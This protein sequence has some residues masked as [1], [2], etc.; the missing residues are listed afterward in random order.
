MIYPGLV[1]VTFRDHAPQDVLRFAREAG[2]QS[3]EWGGDVHCPHGDI[4]KARVIR[5]MTEDAGLMINGY[6]SYYRLGEYKDNPNFL[7]VLASAV[8]LRA[9]TIRVW[10]GK[11]KLKDL[12]LDYR[13]GVIADAQRICEIAEQE[14][15][16]VSTEYHYGTLTQ[17]NASAQALFRDVGHRNMRTFWQP[18][19]AE[20]MASIHDNIEG[21]QKILPILTNIHVFHWMTAETWKH[22]K[23]PL[24]EGAFAWKRYLQLIHSTGRNHFA[25]I[26]FVKNGC[27]EQL[28]ADA[29]VLRAWIAALR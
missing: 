9:K 10:A 4:E 23:H 2:L 21:L 3:I 14:G 5:G 13:S 26:E 15:V 16:T 28:K 11:R 19:Y 7:D 6:G 20:Q 29:G 1:S 8:E 12:T 22:E 27:P 24:E 18:L 17:T 25:N